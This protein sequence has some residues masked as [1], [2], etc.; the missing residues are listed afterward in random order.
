MTDI[1]KLAK[2]R[3]DL[4]VA[5][6]KKIEEFIRMAEDLSKDTRVDLV[7]ALSPR[8]DMPAA[9]PLWDVGSWP[10]GDVDGDETIDVDAATGPRRPMTAGVDVAP[11]QAG[12]YIMYWSVIV[13]LAV[14]LFGSL[15]YRNE[16]KLYGERLFTNPV[17]EEIETNSDVFWDNFIYQEWRLTFKTKQAG[18]P[19]ITLFTGPNAYDNCVEVEGG[20]RN[21]TPA[22]DIV[23]LACLPVLED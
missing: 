16:I 10:K 9:E 19:I 7:E 23:V 4:L 21:E 14:A 5:E 17:V 1:I 6:F 3:R 13:I 18:R 22:E 2:E 15:F 8:P 11:S 12:Q 20:L